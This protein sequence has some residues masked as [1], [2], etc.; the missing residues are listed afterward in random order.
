MDFNKLTTQERRSG[1]AASADGSALAQD[2]MKG[3]GLQQAD[4]Q[5]PGGGRGRAGRG[6][7]PRQPRADRRAPAARAARPGALRRLAGAARRRRAQGGRA[8]VRAGRPAAAE[9]RPRRSRACST[10]P[11]RSASGWSD[12]YVST[13]HLF[14]ALEPVPRDEIEA[15]IESIR[16]GQ[17]VT[18]QD[19]EGTYQAL[20]KFGRDLTEAAEAGKLD[21]VIGRDEEIR[22]VIQILSRRTK[23]NP[24]LIGEPGVGKTAIAEGLAQ[25][26]V[27]GD[28]PEGLKDRRVW[29]LDIG[30]LLA[31]A[32]YRGEF[33]ERL[34]AVLAEIKSSDGRV[35]PLHRRAAHDRRRRRGRG[36]G[37]RREPAEA[38]ARARRAALR[39]R[40]DARRVPQAHRE[41]R[42]ARAALRAGLRRR[43]VGR[44][45]DRDPARA[46]GALRGAPRR[47]HPRR[48]ARRRRGAQPPLH[49]RPL[50]A[51][52]GDR[53]RRRGR[54]A[55]A[56]GDRL[57]PARARR[58]E[59]PRHAARDRARG[60]GERD[61]GRRAS[62]SSVRSPRR[63]RS[64]TR[65]PPAGR[66]R[67]RRSSA[68]RTR[69]ARSTSCAWR[70]S[71]PSAR[72]T[73]S[74]SP[75]SAT[76]RCPRSS[77]SSPSASA[78][79]PTRWSRRRSTRTTSRPTVAR[80]TGIPVDRL[81][82][83]ETAKLIHME[84]RLHQ[85]V[86]GQDEAV[87]A[88]A[89][90]LR[91]A[92]TGLQ[93]PDRPIGSFVFLGPTG[94]GKTELARAL[95]EF[96][97]DDEHAM[98]RIDMSEYQERHTVS[99]LVGA[100]PGYVGY[101]EGGQLTEAVRRRPYSVVLLDEIEKAHT[102]VFDVLL[103]VL[104]DGRLTDGQGRTVDFR[105]TVLIMT[106]NIRSAEPMREHF[107][108]EFLNRID[109][110]VEF[111]LAHARADRRDR[112][113]AARAAA[114]AARR[115]RPRA[116]ADR[117]GE[118]GDRRGRL[119]SG[120]RRAAA[121]ARDPAPAREPARAAAARRRLRRRRHDP[122]R[123]AA[124]RPRLRARRRDEPG[125]AGAE[126]GSRVTRGG[127]ST[128][129]RKSAPSCTGGAP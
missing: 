87:S 31:G 20:A 37:R 110:I 33:E 89:N 18:S 77:A 103:Q 92:R 81:L 84:E 16:G 114:R 128:S 122:R 71:A 44:R 115:A 82:E 60:D 107:R 64:A 39:R 43:A 28:V 12:D 106:S 46:E 32:K 4:D 79:R 40:D 120:L 14:L 100:P 76:A 108:P 88:V 47:A 63:R 9:R 83:G 68:S 51:R 38:A 27:A 50:P 66:R 104:D 35:D 111:E 75:R 49:R 73:C 58:G 59:P 101:D 55:A 94:V 78:G 53:P 113:A 52:Q 36:R 102:E 26:I 23:N 98:V 69:R 42:R 72:A 67:R 90:A 15:W 74:A 57:E 41:G 70:P 65:S 34:K 21:P 117:R 80:W 13:E 56:D 45:H 124:R 61:H 10:A 86:V 97:F 105:N 62:R 22:R 119:G 123:R 5:E 48:R 96:M 93:D 95:A 2:R 29:A 30:S 125:S 121:E 17:R 11:T 54:L 1:R 7:A 25:R 85:R 19:P 112:R 116:R 126:P 109:E 24:V 127:S 99:R 129:S 118:G 3:H 91:R 8:A 6:A